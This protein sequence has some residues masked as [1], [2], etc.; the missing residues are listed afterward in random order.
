MEAIAAR[1][2]VSEATLYRRYSSPAAVTIGVVALLDEA[3]QVPDTGSVRD[4]LLG[5]SRGLVRLLKRSAF[6][7]IAA[8]LVGATAVHAD[9]NGAVTSYVARRRLVVEEA[10]RRGIDRGELPSETDPR[11]VLDLILGPFYFRHLI[12]KDSIDNAFAERVCDSALEAAGLRSPERKT[13]T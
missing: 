13:P 3:V 2:G 4:D 9:L 5:V 6:G 11:F 10:S 7:G 1:A 12:S 8:A